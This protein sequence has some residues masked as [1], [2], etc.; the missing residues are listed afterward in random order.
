MAVPAHGAKGPLFALASYEAASNS[1]YQEDNSWRKPTRHVEM[2][3]RQ[4]GFFCSAISSYR[5]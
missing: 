2:V 5:P 3:G 4:T 1:W